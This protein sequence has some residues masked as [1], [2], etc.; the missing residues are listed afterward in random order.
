MSLTKKITI[1][2]SSDDDGS[3]TLYTC[4]YCGVVNSYF[5]YGC[6]DCDSRANGGDGLDD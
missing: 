1:F 3:L 5:K 4:P 6:R 2:D